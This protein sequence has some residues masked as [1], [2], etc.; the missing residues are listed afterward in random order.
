[1]H[2]QTEHTET[3]MKAVSQGVHLLTMW[4]VVKL[5]YMYF[6]PVKK[7][8]KAQMIAF[9]LFSNPMDR[10]LH[11]MAFND[12]FMMLYMLIAVYLILNNYPVASSLMVSVALSMKAGVLFVLPG[13]MGSIQYNF[14]TITLI[15]SILVLFAFQVLVALPFIMGDTPIS[16][17]LEKSRLT[18]Q[19][20]NNFGY[21]ADHF[22]FIAAEYSHSIFWRF[23][24]EETYYTREKLA[25]FVKPA[26]LALNIYH[27]FLRK[28]CLP[29][30]LSNLLETFSGKKKEI[31]S[32]N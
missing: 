16:M 26:T 23:L 11:H 20:K 4:I 6:N 12:Q 31:T 14:G 18:G 21:E 29:Q 30:C 1:M 32:T 25:V 9:I 24:S 13:F 22:N 15:K 28:N 17:Y 19:G 3:I 7:A 2:L 10:F 27:F 8:E 5:S